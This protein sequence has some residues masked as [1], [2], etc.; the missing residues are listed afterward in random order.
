MIYNV[1]NS[2]RD[3]AKLKK[4]TKI[5]IIF[6]LGLVVCLVFSWYFENFTIKSVNETL[7]SPKINGEIKIA[8]I[9]DLHSYSFGKDN[10]RI[11][12]KL[13]GMSPDLIFVLGDLYSRGR[14]DK[15]EQA[16]QFLE[17]LADIAYVY[18]VTGDHDYDEIYKEKL[19]E[20]ENVKYLES[21]HDDIEIGGCK[22]RIYGSQT[23]YF[24]PTYDMKKRL[25]PPQEDRV[26]ILL[27][28]IPAMEQYG[29]FGFDYIFCGDTHGGAIRLPF[30]GGIYYNGYILPKLTYD[31]EITDKGLYEY[32]KTSLFVT[33]GLGNYPI[34]MRFNNRPEI[35]LI[36]IKGE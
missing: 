22:L 21:E 11:F 4:K 1:I 16:I 30:L 25:D 18:T 32:E 31:G 9:S 5:K 13:E 6:A 35:C 24:Y 12:E 8:V 26:N 17:N 29:D 20:L 36:T 14:T 27:A 15:I 3:V 19:R 23:V 7:T 10:K 28:H 34:P 2:F 33:S